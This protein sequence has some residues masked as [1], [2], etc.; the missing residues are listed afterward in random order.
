M[1]TGLRRAPGGG[2]SPRDDP[3]VK[4][5]L[6]SLLIAVIA[7]PVAVVGTFLLTPLW[8]WLEARTGIESIGHSGPADWCFVAIYLVILLVTLGV[9]LGRRARPP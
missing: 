5:F 4:R 1:G 2:Q 6:L 7:L 9:W 3:L 8:R